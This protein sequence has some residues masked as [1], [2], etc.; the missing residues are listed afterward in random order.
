MEK[1]WIPISSENGPQNVK[2]VI[3]MT[4]AQLLSQILKELKLLRKDL[5][6]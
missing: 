4:I 2:E 3:H 1:E 5:K 6:K